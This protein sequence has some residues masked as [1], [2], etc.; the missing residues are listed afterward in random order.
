VWTDL[1]EDS[2]VRRLEDV[3]YNNISAT[4][5]AIYDRDHPRYPYKSH[6]QWLKA[7]YGLTACIML[8]VFNK[9]E[10]FLTKP[11]NTVGFVY[12]YIGVSSPP[13]YSSLER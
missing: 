9:V 12:S 2:W 1:A 3:K 4:R 13:N 8:M 10:A 7:V 11:F 6:G 5:A